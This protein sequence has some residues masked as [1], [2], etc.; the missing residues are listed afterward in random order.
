MCVRV[1]ALVCVWTLSGI[2]AQC[3]LVPAFNKGSLS[4]RV[5]SAGEEALKGQRV[6]SIQTWLMPLAPGVVTTNRHGF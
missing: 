5:Y 4:D 1:S 3:S 6:S 2:E